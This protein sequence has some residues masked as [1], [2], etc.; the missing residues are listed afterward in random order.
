MRSITIFDIMKMHHHHQ[1]R[2]DW[3]DGSEGQ[4]RHSAC[5]SSA[6][7]GEYVEEDEM[8][9]GRYLP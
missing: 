2:R 4:H 5:S 3:K 9:G 1:Q 6:L 7:T 8:A